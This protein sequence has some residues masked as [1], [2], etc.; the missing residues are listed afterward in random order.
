MFTGAEID[1]QPRMFVF[2]YKS[3][4]HFLEVFRMFYGPIHK[5]FGALDAEKGTAL[6]AD[7]IA[8][9][10]EFN[11]ADDCTM[12]VHSEYLEVIVSKR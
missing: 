7:L 2:R 5:A 1:A 4:Q 10:G 12:A 9:I 6:A 11:R 8:L 3:P